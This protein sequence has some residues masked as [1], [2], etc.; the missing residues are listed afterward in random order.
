MY[1]IILKS[2]EISRARKS[3]CFPT[4]GIHNAD[5]H[6]FF[7]C[8]IDRTLASFTRSIQN[9]DLCYARQDES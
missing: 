2:A 9:H 4:L 6:E 8:R 3:I 5:R 7:A 1:Y